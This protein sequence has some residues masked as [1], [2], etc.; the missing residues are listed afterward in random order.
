MS[1]GK[2]AAVGECVEWTGG[3]HTDGYGGWTAPADENGKAKKW[4]AHRLAWTILVGPIPEGKQVN[5]HCDNRICVNTDHLYLGTQAQNMADK[6]RR[7]RQDKGESHGRAK[8]TLLLSGEMT[9]ST[10]HNLAVLR[11]VLLKELY[12]FVVKS[13]VR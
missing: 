9:D 12:V 8:L 11:N 3:K 2:V 4:R 5:H 13:Q 1:K 7:N 6:V 10:R